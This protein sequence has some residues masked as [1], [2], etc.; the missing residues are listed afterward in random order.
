MFVYTDRVDSQQS[1]H[2]NQQVSSGEVSLRSDF[3]SRAPP[4][5]KALASSIAVFS[6]LAPTHGIKPAVAINFAEYDCASTRCINSMPPVPCD[7]VSGN[8]SRPPSLR[9]SSHTDAG[10]VTPALM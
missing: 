9:V 6:S 10:S 5:K 2:L 3:T 7:D 8:K 1:D 4:L